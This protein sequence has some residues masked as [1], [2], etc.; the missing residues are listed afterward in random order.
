MS[1]RYWLTG[2]SSGIGEALARELLEQGCELIVSARSAERLQALVD[3]YPERCRVL[4]VDLTD[5]DQ[6]ARARTELEG[7]CD[8]LDGVIVNA[9]TCEYIDVKAFDP[10]PFERVMAINFQGAVNTL[11]LALPLLRRTGRAQII[12]IGSMVTRLPLPRSQAYGGSKAAFE[13]LMSSLR[14]DLAA[15]GIDV[16]LV[17]PGFVKTPLTDRNDFDMPFLQTPEQAARIIATGIHKRRRIVQFPRPLVIIMA[18]VRLLPLGLQT[19]FL[20]K[21]SRNQEHS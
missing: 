9:G 1:K 8:Y 7:L 16:T 6:L 5:A 4:A 2:A 18:L 17:R 15:E 20:K 12:G 14:V 10:A 19:G 21:L 3:A 13:Y 11:A